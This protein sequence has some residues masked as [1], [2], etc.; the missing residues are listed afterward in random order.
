MT[1]NHV[2]RFARLSMLLFGA[3][4]CTPVPR[5]AV[6][7]SQADNKHGF[8]V[9]DTIV[10]FMVECLSG[11]SRNLG[12]KGSAQLVTFSTAGDCSTC[13]PHLDGL[14]RVARD[15]RG[16][17]DSFIL[18]WA[19][20]QTIAEVG[21]LY[22]ARPARDV[23]VDTAGRAWDSLNLEHTPV[24]VLLISGHVSYMTDKGYQTDSSRDRF[25]DDLSRISSLKR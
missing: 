17:S 15:G 19:P 8:A 5:D 1:R 10:P 25:L 24:T 12:E 21:R 22:A 4:A 23:C 9:G 11:R 18:T 7:T 13:M 16:P 14:E 3:A 2:P 20:G 6:V